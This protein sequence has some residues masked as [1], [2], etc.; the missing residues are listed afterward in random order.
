MP[1]GRQT[2]YKTNAIFPDCK[3]VEE[4][5]FPANGRRYRRRENRLPNLDLRIEFNAHTFGDACANQID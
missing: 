2:K 1:K 5:T 4:C 3:V